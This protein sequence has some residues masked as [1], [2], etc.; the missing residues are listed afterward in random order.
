MEAKTAMVLKL[1]TELYVFTASFYW[2]HDSIKCLKTLDKCLGELLKVLYDYDDEVLMKKFI[3]M[4]LMAVVLC[5]SSGS[6]ARTSALGLLLEKYCYCLSNVTGE[7]SSVQ[8]QFLKPHYGACKKLVY[9]ENFDSEGEI[10]FEQGDKYKN[11]L[12]KVEDKLPSESN[13]Y[14]ANFTDAASDS[15]IQNNRFICTQR[16]IQNWYD[17]KYKPTLDGVVNELELEIDNKVCEANGIFLDLKPSVISCRNNLKSLLLNYDESI[18]H[19]CNSS[20]ATERA[21]ETDC[22]KLESYKNIIQISKTGYFYDL[23]YEQN[24]QDASKALTCSSQLADSILKNKNPKDSKECQNKSIYKTQNAIQVCKNFFLTKSMSLITESERSDLFACLGKGNKSS[25]TD[26]M[27]G[28]CLGKTIE[29]EN[30][31]EKELLAQL[32]AMYCYEP[33]FNTK[34]EKKK[35]LEDLILNNL[36]ELDNIAGCEGIFDADDKIR[37]QRL[38]LYEKLLGVNP[39]DPMVANA[40]WNNV[41]KK[42]FKE[43]NQCQTDAAAAAKE[44][45]TC[46]SDQVA[47]SDKF[48]S[49]FSKIKPKDMALD[50]LVRNTRAKYPDR[51]EEIKFCL[52]K[53]SPDL[54]NCLLNLHSGASPDIIADQACAFEEDFNTCKANQDPSSLAV[55]PSLVT[56]GSNS[57]GSPDTGLNANSAGAAAGASPAAGKGAGKI[58]GGATAAV[59]GAAAI[60]LFSGVGKGTS[61][62]A[63]QISGLANQAGFTSEKEKFDLFR[64]FKNMKFKRHPDHLCKNIGKGATLRVVGTVGGIVTAGVIHALVMKKAKKET[65]QAKAFDHLKHIWKGVLAGVVVKLAFNALANGIYKDTEAK[66]QTVLIAENRVP[67]CSMADIPAKGK[68][69]KKKKVV[70]APLNYDINMEVQNN[71]A[72]FS[73]NNQESFNELLHITEMDMLLAEINHGVDFQELNELERTY[74]G[75]KYKVQRAVAKIMNNLLIGNAL[76]DASDE[77]AGSGFDLQ[78]L[79]PLVQFLPALLDSGKQKDKEKVAKIE[80][81]ANAPEGAISVAE[82]CQNGQAQS[83]EIMK[84]GN[85]NTQHINQHVLPAILKIKN[86]ADLGDGVEAVNDNTV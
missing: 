27:I 73:E 46:L 58:L 76:A 83:D 81:K 67:V 6:F 8:I 49:C 80:K 33:K 36:S 3:K 25:L 43:R 50:F 19:V 2:R 16:R 44:V 54:E 62:A 23:C 77:K 66:A 82:E 31:K 38:K 10:P 39:D 20:F 70:L 28:S 52:K 85:A 78:S 41:E 48:S 5:T 79:M 72:L 37:C 34:T 74:P 63:N 9:T 22:L 7:G 11:A 17:E 29:P 42:S 12:L 59:T 60:G 18:Y 45:S 86:D 57:S 75:F 64:S 47:Q 15:F 53:K 21:K 56:G 40:C 69:N 24:G 26:E 13:L 35:C 84:N 30:D 61:G 4:L 32:E 55:D 14:S 71:I 65:G 51:E 68:R 1:I